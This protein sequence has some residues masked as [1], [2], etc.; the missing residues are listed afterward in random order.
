MSDDEEGGVVRAGL[1]EEEMKDTFIRLVFQGDAASL[2]RFLEVL[3]QTIPEDTAVVVR[4]SSV[5]GTRWDDS[6][7]FDGD[8]PGTSDIDLTLVGGEVL[9][10]YESE[11]FYVPG[12]HSKPLSEDHPDIAPRLLPLRKALMSI[13]HRPVNIQGTRDFVMLLREHVMRQPYLT[14]LGKVEED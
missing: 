9:G 14:L 7:P 11:G 8:G 4:G 1:S 5:T 3:R 13:V 12:I 10:L 2:E 6:A